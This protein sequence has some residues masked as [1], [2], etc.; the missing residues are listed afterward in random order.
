ML[1]YLI[2]Q[3]VSLIYALLFPSNFDF[4]VAT[5]KGLPSW[6]QGHNRHK[7]FLK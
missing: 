1:L 5:L 6:C 3:N 2:M 4:C 7:F